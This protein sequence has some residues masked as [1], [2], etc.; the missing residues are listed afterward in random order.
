MRVGD[1]EVVGIFDGYGYEDAD[2][3]TEHIRHQIDLAMARADLVLLVVD[4]QAG[5]HRPAWTPARAPF[6]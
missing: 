5:L 3:L 1:I 2:Q 6:C 4:V